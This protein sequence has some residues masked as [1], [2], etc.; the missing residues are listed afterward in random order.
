MCFKQYNVIGCNIYKLYQNLVT[1]LLFF[2]FSYLIFFYHVKKHLCMI[3]MVFKI[4][5]V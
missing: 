5:I 3:M 4:L 1:I 2:V